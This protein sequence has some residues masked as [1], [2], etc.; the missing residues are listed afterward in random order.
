M[1]SISLVNMKEFSKE[2]ADGFNGLTIAN[3]KDVAKY[4]ISH[5]SI[6]AAARPSMDVTV[7]SINSMI[8]NCFNSVINKE[9]FNSAQLA[10]A[11]MIAPYAISNEAGAELYNKVVS[12]AGKYNPA[13]YGA[14]DGLKPSEIN[15][16]REAYDGQLMNNNFVYTILYSFACAKQEDFV[17]AFFPT[18]PVDPAM[19]S[20]T[21]EIQ[22]ASLMKEFFRDINGTPT[23]EKFNKIPLI[24]AI[25]DASI[26][27]TDKNR[28]FPVLRD[29]NKHVLL[30]EYSWETEYT[31]EKIITAPILFDEEVDLLGL[32]Q[33]DS[34]L[35]RGQMDNTDALDR[36]IF[37]DKIWYSLTD[38]GQK[39]M[40]SVSVSDMRNNQ[41]NFNPVDLN[42]DLMLNFRGNNIVINVDSTKTAKGTTST[43]LSKLPAGYSIG[44]EFTMN[45]YANT[46]EGTV[47][48]NPVRKV[49]V[50]YVKDAAG[51]KVPETDGTYTTIKK[52]VS[53]LVFEGYS[54]LAH[55]T[56]SNLRKRGQVLTVDTIRNDY[57]VCWR[58]GFLVI[59]P[60]KSET[61]TDNDAN[62]AILGQTQAIGAKM[63]VCG[64]SRLLS[65][66][67]Y[68][69]NITDNGTKKV[70][71]VQ[72]ET[73]FKGSGQYL[74]EPTYASAKIDLRNIVDSLDSASRDASVRAALYQQ[75]YN[76][77]MK[78][79]IESDF[80]IAFE[81]GLV[82]TEAARPTLILGTDPNIR[83]LLV[84]GGVDTANLGGNFDI[85]IVSTFDKRVEGKI[86]LGF[87]VFDSQRNT[88]PNPI[89]YG[90]TAYS[91][92]LVYDLVRDI[93]G[94]TSREISNQPR[95]THYTNTPVVGYIEVS[96]IE[97]IFDK[98]PLHMKQV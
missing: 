22:Q 56:N 2:L 38:N 64:I 62:S 44:I 97:T 83:R 84:D 54:L 68:L 37:V 52:L 15:I 39:E 7:E 51:M 87:G 43:I 55:S 71:R 47:N 17:E 57:P 31:T 9:S 92:S 3:T 18:I 24:K 21:V 48:V 60:V 91:P 16:S 46:Q 6:D 49:K 1:S 30:K 88:T 81:R 94:Q 98:L 95:F 89:Q 79:Y 76:V 53:S 69:A 10:A 13:E 35:A 29:S 20:I 70:E 36:A 80:G 42:K 8:E 41:F 72:F 25:Y 40:F 77:A 26:F 5:E 61:G 27:D 34:L 59:Q 82:S 74:L 45:G 66:V 85:K 90:F 50:S 11:K 23:R 75:I 32:S 67:E 12:A 86:F 93:N 33:T 78:L 58:S 65:D 14:M 73:G 63:S 19:S 96:G 28:L 4:A